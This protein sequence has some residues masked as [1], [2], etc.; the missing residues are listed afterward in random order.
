M[1]GKILTVGSKSQVFHG[2]AKHTS[3]GLKKSDLMRTK[4]GRIVSRKKHAAGKK[5]IKHLRALGYIAKKGT[6]KL[7]RKS[8]VDGRKHK[9]G[10]RRH[11]RK[12]GGSTNSQAAVPVV[13]P[14]TNGAKLPSM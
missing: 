11:S 8:M 4:A 9:K 6:F 13:T 12:R 10:S 2:S 1:S 14:A 3:G 7:M 5:A